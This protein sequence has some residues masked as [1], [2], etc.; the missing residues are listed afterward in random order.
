MSVQVCRSCVGVGMWVCLCRCLG[1]SVQVS[2]CVCAGVWVRLCR[3]LGASVQVSGCVCAGL[4]VSEQM[5]ACLYICV[6]SIFVC[7]G[8]CRC[9]CAG[10]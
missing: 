9:V 6:G 7:T 5:W 10:V 3:C 1:A 4:D 2:G 8:V